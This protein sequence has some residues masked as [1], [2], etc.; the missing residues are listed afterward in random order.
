MHLLLFVYF[1]F[2]SSEKMTV[3]KMKEQ[4]VFVLSSDATWVC[5]SMGAYMHVWMYMSFATWSQ[6]RNSDLLCV[7]M[8][9]I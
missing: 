5:L 9:C 7:A 2:W 8:S 1:L 6:I 3:L 4:P